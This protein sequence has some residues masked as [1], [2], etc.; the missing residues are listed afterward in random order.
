MSKKLTLIIISAIVLILIFFNWNFYNSAIEK[1]ESITEQWA[2]VESVYQRRADLIPNLVNTA[3]GYAEFEQETFIKVT[4]A[5]SNATSI[6]IDPSNITPEQLKQFEQAQ[7]NLTGA[8]SRLLATFERYPD[9]K[10]QENFKILMNELERT[11]NRINVERNRFNERVTPYN[12]LIRKFPNNLFA[13]IYGFEKKIRFQSD[14]D[15]EVA[16]KVSF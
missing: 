9:L 7:S 14:K 5:R 3:K 15:A 16:P 10:A 12:T 11:E 1:E 8:L 4:E 2:N 6:K 13:S